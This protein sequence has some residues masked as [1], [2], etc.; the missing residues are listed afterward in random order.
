MLRRRLVVLV[1]LVELDVVVVL[2]RRVV[3]LVVLV[4]L[5]VP[6]VV[7]VLRRRLVLVVLVERRRLEVCNDRRKCGTSMWSPVSSAATRTSPVSSASRS[8]RRGRAGRLCTGAHFIAAPG[9]S[10]GISGDQLW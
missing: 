7:V 5:D 10:G 8:P 4:E 3:V 6:D 9:V 2:R 1:V